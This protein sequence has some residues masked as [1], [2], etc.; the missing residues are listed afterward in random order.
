MTDASFVRSIYKKEFGEY[1]GHCSIKNLLKSDWKLV[2]E[3]KAEEYHKGYGT[4]EMSTSA[5]PDHNDLLPASV[6]TEA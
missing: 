5:P 3:L 2:I 4:E 6:S 1:D